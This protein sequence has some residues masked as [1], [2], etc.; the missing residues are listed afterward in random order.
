MWS[1]FHC[2][3][4][5]TSQRTIRCPRPNVA[6]ISEELARMY[7]PDQDPLGQQL[8]FG[9][10]PENS[11]TREIVGV[12]GG[13]RDEALNQAPGPIIYVPFAQAPLWGVGLVIKTSKD[14][15]TVARELEAKVHEVDRD[16]P[17]TDIQWLSETVD[18]SLGP[19]RLRTWLLGLFAAIALT[20]ATAGIFGVMSYSVSLRTHEFGIRMALGA[21]RQDVLNLVVSEGLRL[22]L[23]GVVAGILGALGPT[24]FL[25]S[26]LYGVKP[27]D[28]WTFIV[29]SLGLAG[30]ALLASYVPARR[31]TKVDPMVALRYE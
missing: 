30:V 26:L 9:F 8:I 10:P 14:A 27:S 2:C 1:A 24:R 7:F 19:A 29:V 31:A 3:A 22:T 5:A 4:G 28:P 23:S 17:V 18:S 11:M 6:I 20:L 15:S 13:V 12:V 16:L 25:S 21:R